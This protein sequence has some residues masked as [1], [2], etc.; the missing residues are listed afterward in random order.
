MKKVL[1]PTFVVLLDP[2]VGLDIAQS[3]QDRGYR[4]VKVTYVENN[5]VIVSWK[6]K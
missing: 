4:E 5:K 2:K 3:K 6:S 1:D